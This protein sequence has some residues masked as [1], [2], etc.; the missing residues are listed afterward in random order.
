MYIPTSLILLALAFLALLSLA[1][2]SPSSSFIPRKKSD[3]TCICHSQ[4][5]WC[6]SRVNATDEDAPLQGS[7]AGNTL[8]HCT[9]GDKGKIN[10][11]P[12]ETQ[13]CPDV[14]YDY[15]PGDAYKSAFCMQFHG[16]PEVPTTIVITREVEHRREEFEMQSLPFLLEAFG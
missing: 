16:Q 1:T 14:I 15:I 2:G 6:D 12:A 13:F 4:G 10:P 8:Y 11:K 9:L 5:L 3:N 7:C